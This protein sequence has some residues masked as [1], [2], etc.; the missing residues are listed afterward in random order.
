MLTKEKGYL[1]MSLDK[2]ENQFLNKKIKP[3]CCFETGIKE[4]PILSHNS[5]VEIRTTPCMKSYNF[6]YKIIQTQ[7]KEYPC[8]WIDADHTTDFT[9]FNLKNLL[10]SQPNS[11][12]EC[13]NILSKPLLKCLSIAVIASV[14]NLLP[15]E[16]DYTY[17]EQQLNK[18]RSKIL[19]TNCS[20]I[21]I[22][23]YA[24]SKY[25]IFSKYS[26]IIININKNT[27]KVIKNIKTLNLFSFHYQ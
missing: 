22:N 6:L 3:H 11:P 13:L 27:G 26:D 16:G 2:F 20:I 19:G 23:P 18:L 4:L 14:A 8:L 10:I 17:L 24:S 25:D 15:L 7:L 1:F 5:I 9:Q 12:E 21:F